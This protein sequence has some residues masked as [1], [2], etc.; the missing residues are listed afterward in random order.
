MSI[1]EIIKLNE[2]NIRKALDDY[3]KHTYSSGIL[4][5][6]SDE[7]IKAVAKKSAYSK[8]ALRELFRKSPAWNEELQALIQ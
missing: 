8:S 1:N 4:E 2:S 7:F 3:G 5:E 6:I